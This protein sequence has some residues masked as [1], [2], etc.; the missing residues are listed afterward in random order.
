MNMRIDEFWKYFHFFRNCVPLCQEL[1]GLNMCC[2]LAVLRLLA[3]SQRLCNRLAKLPER[4]LAQPSQLCVALPSN[5]ESLVATAPPRENTPKRS[6][7]IGSGTS[8][9]PACTRAQHIQK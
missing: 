9:A 1:V 5:L 7:H 8:T 3:K 4:L 2:F 6:I